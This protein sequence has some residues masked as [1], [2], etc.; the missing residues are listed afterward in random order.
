VQIMQ[1]LQIY[2]LHY[3]IE[4]RTQRKRHYALKK[5]LESDILYY[6]NNAFTIENMTSKTAF[7]R[8]VQRM[9]RS[10]EDLFIV[11][12][13][14]RKCYRN[15]IYP[16]E[17]QDPSSCFYKANMN[18]IDAILIDRDPNYKIH[19]IHRTGGFKLRT[20]FTQN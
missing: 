20:T 15:H 10:K 17:I 8:Q 1:A 9:M 18:T 16:A 14:L 12:L 19:S 7:C 11:P 4:E 13:H 6:M 5:L 2:N 3:G